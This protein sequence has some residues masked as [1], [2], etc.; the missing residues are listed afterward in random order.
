VAKI[1]PTLPLH[2]I[3]TVERQIYEQTAPKRIMTALMGVF[4]GIALLLAAV[5]LYAVIAYAVSQ[6]THEIGVRM[7]LGARSRDI[8][9]LITGQGLKL[10]IAGLTLGTVGAYALTR[11]MTPLLYG[12]TATDP[13]TFILI[14]LALAGAALLAC[15]IPARRATKVDP[16]IALRCD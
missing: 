6:R 4:A 10:T 15:W 13:L 12:V 2:F 9:R 1:D 7:A 5:G 11:F 8:L 3:K 14:S 16:M